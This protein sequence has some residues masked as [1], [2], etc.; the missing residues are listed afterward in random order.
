MTSMFFWRVMAGSVERVGAFLA[1]R[2]R[3]RPLNP[4]AFPRAVAPVLFR[5]PVR[6]A[7]RP[8]ADDLRHRITG[9]PLFRR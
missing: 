4:P 5:V 3:R 2:T 9:R 7:M 6:A 1:G 8:T